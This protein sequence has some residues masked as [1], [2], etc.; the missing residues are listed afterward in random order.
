MLFKTKYKDYMWL[1]F[2]SPTIIKKKI[3]LHKILTFI[4][5]LIEEQES[6]TERRLS[7]AKVS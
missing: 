1:F 7:F 2:E 4:F 3:L 6:A 5:S